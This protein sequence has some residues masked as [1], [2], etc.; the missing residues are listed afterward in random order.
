MV[1][2][3]NMDYSNTISKKETAWFVISVTAIL[4]VC[5]IVYNQLS[6]KTHLSEF[7][8]ISISFLVG[9]F[10]ATI[11]GSLLVVSD[12]QLINYLNKRT[13]WTGQIFKRSV[14]EVSFSLLL[15]FII[16]TLVSLLSHS[17]FPYSDGLFINVINNALITAVTNLLVISILE[18]WIYY[19]ENK[20]SRRQAEAL[21]KELTSI[22]F[23]VLKSQ[24]NPHFMFNSLSVLSGLV[25]SNP[26]LAQG[27]IADFASVYRYVLECI[28]KPVVRLKDELDFAQ[29][30][31]HL[32]TIRHGKEALIYRVE[33]PAEMLEQGIPPLSLQTVLENALKH[34]LVQTESPLLIN[35]WVEHACLCI[36]NTMQARLSATPSTKVGQNNLTKRY[37]LLYAKAPRFLLKESLYLVELPLIPID[38][39]HSDH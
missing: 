30:Y 26:I 13:P 12:L 15:S 33:V 27:F 6:G 22:R 19:K 17:L 4:E 34:N 20:E 3:L 16:G 37:R 5:I 23:E 11:M 18:A 29:A 38:D 25:K 8:S 21:E 10:F 36:S 24:I 32:Q 7:F 28:D 35:I 14:L 31:M 39:E 1:F 9:W 2:Q